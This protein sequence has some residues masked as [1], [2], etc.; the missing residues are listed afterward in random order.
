MRGLGL[1]AIR[2]AGRGTSLGCAS[3]HRLVLSQLLVTLSHMFAA[4]YRLRQLQHL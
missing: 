2:L 4:G 1:G 3:M